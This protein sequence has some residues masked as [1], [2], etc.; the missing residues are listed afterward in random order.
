MCCAVLWRKVTRLIREDEFIISFKPICLTRTGKRLNLGMLA[1][2]G[3]KYKEQHML[4]GILDCSLEEEEND[5]LVQLFYK[6]T[7]GLLPTYICDLISW[8]NIFFLACASMIPCCFES[9]LSSQE[10]VSGFCVLHSVF[11]SLFFLF[12]FTSGLGC[13]GRL[14]RMEIRN[15]GHPDVKY[16]NSFSS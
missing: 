13:K 15:S 12:A 7:V 1:E 10:R 9:H 2:M 16:S 11:L 3:M 8:K 6:A 14:I 5:S 4:V